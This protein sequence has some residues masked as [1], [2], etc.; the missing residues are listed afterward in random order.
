MRIGKD[1]DALLETNGVMKQRTTPRADLKDYSLAH[2]VSIEWDMSKES[3]RERMFILR[4]D[5]YE[6]ILD[7]EE[8]RKASRFI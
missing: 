5:D 8:F 2:Q 3:E 6:V 4:I 1:Q 7:Y